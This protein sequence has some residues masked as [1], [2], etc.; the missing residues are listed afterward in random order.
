[1]GHIPGAGGSVLQ[2]KIYVG[3]NQCSIDFGTLQATDIVIKSGYDLPTQCSSLLIDET[4]KPTV[5]VVSGS[6][7][8]RFNLFDVQITTERNAVFNAMFPKQL[9]RGTSG[10]K[11]SAVF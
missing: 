4:V 9:F 3:S 8:N 7:T 2:I 5:E 1:M 6:S 11:V 10:R